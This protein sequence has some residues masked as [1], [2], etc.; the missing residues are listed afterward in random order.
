MG[1][2]KFRIA[3]SRL[4]IISRCI[5]CGKVISMDKA[6]RSSCNSERLR[7]LFKYAEK[8]KCG[9]NIVFTHR[10]GV[11]ELKKTEDV[12]DLKVGCTTDESITGG[13]NDITR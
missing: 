2:R 1:K 8:M 12:R 7:R 4:K 3:T 10:S 9:E 6:I 13:N 11:Y 5:M